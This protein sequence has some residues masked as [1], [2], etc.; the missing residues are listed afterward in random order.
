[1]YLNILNTIVK[2]EVPGSSPGVGAMFSTM[3]VISNDTAHYKAIK[4]DW[5]LDGRE[6][7]FTI[8]T[9]LNLVSLSSF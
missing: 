7:T 1:M 6:K 2:R 5:V 9:V 4:A 8:F 3:I